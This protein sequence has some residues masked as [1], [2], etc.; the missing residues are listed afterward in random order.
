[1]YKS[2]FAKIDDRDCLLGLYLCVFASKNAKSEIVLTN[3]FLKN[4][5]NNDRVSEDKAKDLSINLS[6][7][8]PS[9]SNKFYIGD[10][11]DK[12]RYIIKLKANSK[13]GV[14]LTSADI[15][16]IEDIP[17]IDQILEFIKLG[18]VS[19]EIS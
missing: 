4:Y 16:F 12:N 17:D 10:K 18:K 1:M 2:T 15:H 6:Y 19:V 9:E 11:D 7:Y 14:K 3:N 5:F 8:F 13:N